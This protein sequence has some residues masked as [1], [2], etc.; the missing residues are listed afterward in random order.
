MPSCSNPVFGVYT[1]PLLNSIAVRSLEL[2]QYMLES[3]SSVQSSFTE[4]THTHENCGRTAYSSVNLADS[5]CCFLPTRNHTVCMLEPG[6]K[7]F[8]TKVVSKLQIILMNIT[9]NWMLLWQ[10]MNRRPN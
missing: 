10:L 3:D 9:A 2:P 6:L 8:S 1:Y 4:T 7:A 5:S